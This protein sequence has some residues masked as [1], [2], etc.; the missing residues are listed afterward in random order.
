M[1]KCLLN[2][3]YKQVNTFSS[4]Y[5]I[6]FKAKQKSVYLSEALKILKSYHGPGYYDYSLQVFKQIQL[7]NK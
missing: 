7:V 6:C 1:P 2:T 3:L 5:N 4:I